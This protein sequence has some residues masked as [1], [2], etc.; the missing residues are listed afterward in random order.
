MVGLALDVPSLPTREADHNSV[1]GGLKRVILTAALRL[2]HADKT[3]MEDVSH[4]FYFVFSDGVGDPGVLVSR[5]RCYLLFN[6]WRLFPAHDVLCHDCCHLR[7]RASCPPIPFSHWVN[8][9]HVVW[10]LEKGIL[11]ALTFGTSS[12]SKVLPL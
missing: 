10:H 1:S 3:V 8:K 12:Q 11:Q 4:Y 2:N 5:L 7:A 6:T 9:Q